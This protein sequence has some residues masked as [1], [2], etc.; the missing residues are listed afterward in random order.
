M[1]NGYGQYCPLALA[2]ELLGQRWSILVISRLLDG[3]TTF[4][5]IQRGVPR[6]SPSMLSKRLEE[7]EHAGLIRRTTR[8]G[9]TAY[10]LTEA[11]KDLDGIIMDLAIWGQK[12]ARDMTMDDLDPAFLAWSMHTRVD[13]SVFG[14]GRTVIEFEFSGTPRGTDTF[15]LVFTD[16]TVDMCLKYPGFETDLLVK[17]DLLRFVETWRG[18]RSLEDE[19]YTGKIRL[20]GPPPLKRAF[21]SCLQL[22]ALAPWDRMKPGREKR[23]ASHA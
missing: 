12:W 9:G 11:G 10:Q 4:S 23:I 15:W 3:C 5:E 7:F 1:N 21:P 19:L 16:G 13:P 8:K 2:T 20:E 17:A 22:S 14:E 18:F 6:I